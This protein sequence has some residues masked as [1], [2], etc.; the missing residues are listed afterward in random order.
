MS[1]SASENGGGDDDRWDDRP[2]GVLGGAD[3]L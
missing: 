3:E 1:A 2:P